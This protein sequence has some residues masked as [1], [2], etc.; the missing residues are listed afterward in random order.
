MPLQKTE[1]Q[2]GKQSQLISPA[3][4]LEFSKNSDRKQDAE[5]VHDDSG[6]YYQMSDDLKLSK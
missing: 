6:Y 2:Q 3:Y 1:P 5:N 4:L